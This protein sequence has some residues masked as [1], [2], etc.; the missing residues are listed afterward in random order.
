M[1]MMKIK[2][3][4]CKLFLYRYHLKLSYIYIIKREISDEDPYD[5]TNEQLDEE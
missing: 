2:L 1:M 3:Y 4:T 5:A